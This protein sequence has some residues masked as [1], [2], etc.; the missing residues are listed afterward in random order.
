MG[1]VMLR[2]ASVPSRLPSAF[3]VS[4]AMVA[5]VSSPSGCPGTIPDDAQRKGPGAAVPAAQGNP[6]R[7]VDGIGDRD[8]DKGVNEKGMV[9]GATEGTMRPAMSRSS[10]QA[11]A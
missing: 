11:R 10:R 7:G 5:I 6:R 1:A 8:P 2:V 3:W 4:V 9:F